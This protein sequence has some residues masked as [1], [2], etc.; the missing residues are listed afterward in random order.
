MFLTSSGQPYQAPQITSHK[1]KQYSKNF[2]G[3]GVARKLLSLFF[4]GEIDIEITDKNGKADEKVEEVV[5]N[6][7]TAPDVSLFTKMRMG[8][9]DKFWQG[10]GI[11]DP[12]WELRGPEWRLIKLTRLPPESFAFRAY[13]VGLSEAG[14]QA[15][16]PGA[17]LRGVIA[18]PDGNIRYFQTTNTHAQQELVGLFVVKHSHSPEVAG[19]PEILPVTPVI[20]MLDFAFKAQMQKVNRVG[21]P[22]LL[23]QIT[24]PK[25]DD[26]QY[27]EKL[28][29]NWGKDTGFILRPNFTIVDF[30][31]RDTQ[32]ALETINLL[33]DMLMDYWVPTSMLSKTGTLIGG[34]SNSDL[35]LIYSFIA[36]QH[37]E[38]EA[39]WEPL[40][41]QY[42]DANGYDGYRAKIHIEDP[43]IDIS[44]LALEQAKV[45]STTGLL[46][47]NEIRSRLGAREMTEAELAKLP[48]HNKPVIPAALAQ[49]SDQSPGQAP[50]QPGGNGGDGNGPDQGSD[51]TQ[52]PS[53]AKGEVPEEGKQGPGGKGTW[54][55][56]KPGT[57]GAK[58]NPVTGKMYMLV[59]TAQD[60]PAVL[61]QWPDEVSPTDPN[62]VIKAIETK[63]E[64]ELSAALDVLS[65]KIIAEL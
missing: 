60:P 29:K 7:M 37:R 51:P 39:E 34:N 59:N 44:E 6:M 3:A 26:I 18:M 10:L 17:I 30:N 57:P 12:T 53:G 5:E 19:E 47:D 22:I 15:T 20:T 1:L 8:W 58:K 48:A 36:G 64:K 32:A 27:G 33:T 49:G 55:E 13:V 28:I 9:T 65:R 50:G 46:D 4:A 54:K 40:I 56:V 62:K 45:G 31:F 43:E 42:L 2:Y 14:I 24:N 61:H 16:V 25:G 63:E 38:T 35:R 41:Q 21:A 52:D 11:F 23:L